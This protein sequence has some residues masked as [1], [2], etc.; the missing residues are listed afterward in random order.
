M[1]DSWFS[2]FISLSFWRIKKPSKHNKNAHN[3]TDLTT[4]TRCPPI[5]ARVSR[6]PTVMAREWIIFKC[7][8][9]NQATCKLSRQLLLWVHV[10]KY[11]EV[12]L[13]DTCSFLGCS[14]ITGGVLLAPAATTVD[15]NDG[16]QN[17]QTKEANTIWAA[18]FCRW[19]FQNACWTSSH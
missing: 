15:G 7:N 4:N 8:T 12:H 5:C 17:Q 16:Q 10:V 2:V 14:S 3:T 1:Y 9:L 19:K 11:W 18:L 6:L 13:T